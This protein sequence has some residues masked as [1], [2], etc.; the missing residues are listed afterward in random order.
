MFH[1]VILRN[2]QAA[3]HYPITETSETGVVPPN[4]TG[5]VASCVRLLTHLQS[6]EVT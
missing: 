5:H 4:L 6:T 3:P 1:I 2:K